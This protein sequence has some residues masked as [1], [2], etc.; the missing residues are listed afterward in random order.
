MLSHLKVLES[1]RSKIYSIRWMNVGLFL[2]TRCVLVICQAWSL[3]SHTSYVLAAS[4]YCL[5]STSGFVQLRV[6]TGDGNIQ[7]SYSPFNEILS[8]SAVPGWCLWGVWNEGHWRDFDGFHEGRNVSTEFSA[9]SFLSITWLAL[10]LQESYW[11]NE[12]MIVI[13]FLCN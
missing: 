4:S 11:S 8:T 6:M 1:E 13:R 7:V 5:L 2:Y 3:K 12:K 10:Q 9:T